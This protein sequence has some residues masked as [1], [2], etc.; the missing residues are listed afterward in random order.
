MALTSL[1]RQSPVRRAQ[2]A[3]LSSS[4]PLSRSN[5][6]VPVPRTCTKFTNLHKITQ[7]L[8]SYVQQLTTSTPINYQTKINQIQ[9]P[10]P[11]PMYKNLSVRNQFP[12]SQSAIRIPQ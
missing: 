3:N 5:I 7:S 9:K 12:T 6:P 10:S 2:R 1:L 8:S 4:N 11:T